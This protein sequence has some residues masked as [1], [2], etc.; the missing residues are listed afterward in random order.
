MRQLV[1]EE[2]S[3]AVGLDRRVEH[4]G[5]TEARGAANLTIGIP[6]HSENYDTDSDTRDLRGCGPESY[7]LVL[8]WDAR[9]FGFNGICIFKLHKDAI[10]KSLLTTCA[11]L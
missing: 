10:A 9:I 5:D 6:T 8:G 4:G 7:S 3:A 11:Y 1:W 2:G